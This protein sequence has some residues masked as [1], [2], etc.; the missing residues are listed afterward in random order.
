[1]INHIRVK[2]ANHKEF[3]S[4]NVKFVMDRLMRLKHPKW[5]FI[6]PINYRY[7]PNTISGDG[8]ELDEYI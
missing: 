4:K 3:L 5:K 7:V 2:K 1:M 6:Y 8:E